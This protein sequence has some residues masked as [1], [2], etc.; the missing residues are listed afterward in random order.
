MTQY[1]IQPHV[2][3]CSYRSMQALRKEARRIWV[4]LLEIEGDGERIGDIGGCVG[5][6]DDGDGP[7]G[8]TVAL[9]RCWWNTQLCAEWGDIGVVNP[10]CFVR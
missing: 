6:V 10:L 7:G 1:A 8:T 2:L 9:G 4:R 3:E 5:V